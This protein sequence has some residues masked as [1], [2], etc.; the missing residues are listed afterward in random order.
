MAAK[1]ETD[2]QISTVYKKEELAKTNAESPGLVAPIRSQIDGLV[3]SIHL[4]AIEALGVSNFSQKQCLGRYV[5]TKS[6]RRFAV[7]TL[8]CY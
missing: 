6:E 4:L 1:I 7:K 2:S 8:H 5:A 3:L